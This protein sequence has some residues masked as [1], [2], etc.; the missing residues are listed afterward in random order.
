MRM[1]LLFFVTL[2][3]AV[4]ISFCQQCSFDFVD[5]ECKS[6]VGGAKDLAIGRGISTLLNNNY[7]YMVS[8]QKQLSAPL[9]PISGLP[10]C[11]E[12]FCGGTMIS[13][14][15]VLTAAHCFPHLAGP[16]NEWPSERVYA[17]ISP[18]CRHLQNEKYGRL[19]V[20]TVKIHPSYDP[21]SKVGDLAVIE[22]IGQYDGEVVKIVNQT[23]PLLEDEDNVEIIGYGVARPEEGSGQNRP[24]V[25]YPLHGG[26]LSI[27]SDAICETLMAN[28]NE[29]LK[30]FLD[31]Q[32]M[33]CGFSRIAD[34]CEGD[35]GGPLLRNGV[36]YG[37]ASWGPATSCQSLNGQQF[38]SVFTKIS[39]YF[40]WINQIISEPIPNPVS[41]STTVSITP[42]PIPTSPI[43]TP[44][45][46]PADICNKYEVQVGDVFLMIAEK[47]GVEFQ[48]L[49]KANP[50]V[51]PDLIFSG[52]ILNVPPCSP[53]QQ[54][55][56][57]VKCGGVYTAKFGD[58]FYKIALGLGITVEQLTDLNPQINDINSISIGQ[59]INK[60]PC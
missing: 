10:G 49:V 38:P 42:I 1:R 26:N 5:D 43:P 54:H 24:L 35:S 22:L 9:S 13:A 57:N 40:E 20:G 4:K 17:A 45:S 58:S 19:L 52:Q 11:F 53:I 32:T 21:I 18:Q 30:F 29:E 39:T 15:H 50:K 41:T 28:I 6:E 36:Q 33:I 55:P 16:Q 3:T 37:I 27:I 56:E 31:F 51:N 7:P 44:T 14:R 23:S 47:L 2:I 60:P 8:F 46:A 34:T 59:K 48:E 12:H 25:V